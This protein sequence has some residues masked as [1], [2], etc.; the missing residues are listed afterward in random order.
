MDYLIC[1]LFEV[2]LL[3][4]CVKCL[5]SLP[6]DTFESTSTSL[7]QTGNENSTNIYADQRQIHNV[8]LTVSNQPVIGFGQDLANETSLNL[9]QRKDSTEN[10]ADP[11]Y[12]ENTSSGDILQKYITSTYETVTDEEFESSKTSIAFTNESLKDESDVTKNTATNSP[13]FTSTQ[14]VDRHVPYFVSNNEMKALV[15]THDN[16]RQRMPFQH[17]LQLVPMEDEPFG[18]FIMKDNR[19]LV[20]VLIPIGV[21]TIGAAMIVVTVLSLRYIA[22]RRAVG[23]MPINDDVIVN[24]H[25]SSVASISGEQTDRVFL[26]IGEED[27]I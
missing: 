26:L 3:V 10:D 18:T 7:Q 11:P 6:S 20:S 5:K 2:M 21:G 14:N 25:E 15:L 8:N 4:L 24:K 1:R 12:I 23:V 9:Y 13:E 17:H 22:R 16:G 19:L 27:D